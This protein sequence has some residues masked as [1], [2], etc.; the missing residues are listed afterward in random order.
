MNLITQGL[1]TKYS[2]AGD[3]DAPVVVL[4]HGW[5]ASS[6]NF[7]ALAAHL[8]AR[9]RVIWLDLPGF[10][11]TQAPP[12]PWHI[13]D[14]A[15]FVK[16]FLDKLKIP[17]PQAVIGHSFGGRTLIAGV[18][19]G[20]LKPKN[21]VLMGSAGI[22][23]SDT[24]RNQIFKLIAKTGKAVTLLPG[25]SRLRHRLRSR[26]YQAAGSDDYLKSGELRQT[27]LN[28][29]GED[30][31]ADAAHLQI[32]ALLIWGEHDTDTPLA[33]GR[34]LA[35]TIPHATLKVVPGA[36]HYVHL[37]APAEVQAAIDGFLK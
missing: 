37:D 1:F 6:Q 17:Q 18:S 13:G 8:A 23:H 24:T 16:T 28:T 4:L 9:F 21:I 10:G 22:K 32:P 29:I 15:E 3:R 30:L 26:L 14:Y 20:I 36:G 5:G 31:Q 35:A 25:L 11:G 7:D 33:D 27:F 19:R 34:L 2:D 12:E